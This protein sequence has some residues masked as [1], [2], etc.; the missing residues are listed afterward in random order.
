MAQSYEAEGLIV[1]LCD[2][3][4]RVIAPGLSPQTWNLA[5]CPN[6]GMPLGADW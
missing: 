6:D 4:T 5:L 2:G 3:S 1:A